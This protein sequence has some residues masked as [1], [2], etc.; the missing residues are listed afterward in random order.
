MSEQAKEK[1]SGPIG[2]FFHASQ[3][4]NLTRAK[5]LKQYENYMIFVA[6]GRFWKV[7]EVFWVLLEAPWGRLGPLERA[8]RASWDH[9]GA[10]WT[11][12]RAS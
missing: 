2:T 6:L 1:G 7:W 8:R 10:S 9:L 5:T 4:Q 12:W 11:V 3:A